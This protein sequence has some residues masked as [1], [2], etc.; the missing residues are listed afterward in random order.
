MVY[1][2]LIDS[3]Q[4]ETWSVLISLSQRDENEITRCVAYIYLAD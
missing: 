3:I 1:H 2:N 4:H